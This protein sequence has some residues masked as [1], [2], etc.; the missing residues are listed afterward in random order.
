MVE[1][2]ARAFADLLP[3]MAAGPLR[4]H[5][6]RR[7]DSSTTAITDSAAATPNA[8]LAPIQP[9][10]RPPSAGPAAKATVRASSRRA[11]AAGS[12]VG[13]TSD[14]TSAGAATL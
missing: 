3:G 10:S 6:S 11:L 12:I 1:D 13:P 7:P 9:T 2:E 14:G 5:G 8:G 4:A